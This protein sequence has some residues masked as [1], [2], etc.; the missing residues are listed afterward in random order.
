MEIVES[1]AIFGAEG[2]EEVLLLD[3]TP[4]ADSELDIGRPTPDSGDNRKDCRRVS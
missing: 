2:P 4:G 1:P 3:E